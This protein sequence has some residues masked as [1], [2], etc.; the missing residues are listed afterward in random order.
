MENIRKE[1]YKIIRISDEDW[2]LFEEIISSQKFKA[3]TQIIKNG[4]IARDLF[5][6]EEGLVR[7]Y[8]YSDGKEVNTYFACDN[9]YI[10]T[11]ASVV[12]QLPS[13]EILETITDS[14]ILKI[15]Y[16]KLQ[17]L[18]KRIPKFER[19]GRILAEKNY[20]C[21]NDRTVIMQT[22]TAREKYLNFIETNEQKIVQQIPQR[23][24]ASFLGITPESL[25]RVRRELS[26]STQ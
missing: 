17:Q 4:S 13:H 3:K 23:L 24:I 10:S 5:F 20:L 21:I 6:I 22:Q 9:Q 11:Y 2:S 12:T 15:N 18:Y 8:H 26:I 25:S 7:V 19:L 14:S 16:Q 1:I